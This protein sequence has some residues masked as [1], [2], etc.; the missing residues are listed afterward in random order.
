MDEIQLLLMGI[1]AIFALI[2]GGA[3]AI[4]KKS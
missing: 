1:F 3:L 2:Y 4:R